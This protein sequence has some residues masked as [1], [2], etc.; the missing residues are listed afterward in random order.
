ME[1]YSEKYKNR[2]DSFELKKIIY[3]QGVL[4]ATSSIFFRKSFDKFNPLYYK[5]EGCVEKVFFFYLRQFG[6]FKYFTECCSFYR[7]HNKSYMK[8][9]H[10]IAFR[11]NLL[12]TNRIL[13]QSF[14]IANFFF[15]RKIILNRILLMKYYLKELKIKLGLSQAL[16]IPIDIFKCLW[17]T[18]QSYATH[19]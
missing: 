14:P 11:K 6:E 5:I 7:T 2:T 1:L 8:S 10:K 3:Y 18:I 16:N 12:N 9:V 13:W 15:T 4:G 17:L 19:N